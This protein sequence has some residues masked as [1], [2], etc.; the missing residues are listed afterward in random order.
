MDDSKS[1]KTT[2]DNDED[3]EDCKNLSN[4]PRSKYEVKKTII[5]PYPNY[6]TT[7]WKLI[8]QGAEARIWLLPNYFSISAPVHGANSITTMSTDVICKERF[9]KSYRLQQINSILTKSRMKSEVKCLMKARKHGID[10]PNILGV[11]FNTADTECNNVHSI[12]FFMEYLKEH[13]TVR[14]YL[15]EHLPRNDNITRDPDTWH[16]YEI[17]Q[18]GARSTSDNEDERP[19]TIKK[20][21]SSSKASNILDISMQRI[22]AAIGTVM[23]KLHT[24]HLIHGDLTTSNMMINPKI[25]LEFDYK[26]NSCITL[27]DFGLGQTGCSNPEEKAVDLYVFERALISSHP[28]PHTSLFLDEVLRSYK[29]YNKGSDSVLSRLYQVRLRGRKRECFG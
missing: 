17:S 28:G 29:Q 22:A 23:A 4:T 6:Y 5:P 18:E 15:N 19:I 14:K 9:Y 10:V 11:D 16:G 7:D 13:V 2:R 24:C 21:K 12:C 20:H 25:P 27:I 1:P 26:F 3:C 8:S